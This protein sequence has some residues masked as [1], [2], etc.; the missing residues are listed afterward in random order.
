M[1]NFLVA[2]CLASLRPYISAPMCSV[3]PQPMKHHPL[4][5]QR[6]LLIPLPHSTAAHT[7]YSCKRREIQLPGSETGSV[8]SLCQK[9]SWSLAGWTCLSSHPYPTPYH[10]RKLQT[11]LE[12]KAEA[13]QA[14]SL[15]PAQGLGYSVTGLL[16]ITRFLQRTMRTVHP[17]ILDLLLVLMNCAKPFMPTIQGFFSV[18]RMTAI[19][20]WGVFAG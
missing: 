10:V 17:E 19:S 12:N 7:P 18:L 20:T 13:H 9:S 4:S 6:G 15:L 14:A 16:P 5:R 8:W 1:N 11:L 3:S 2:S